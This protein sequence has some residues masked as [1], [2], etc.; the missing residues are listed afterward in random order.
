MRDNTK[1]YHVLKAIAEHDGPATCREI[2]DEMSEEYRPQA[3]D[4]D[5]E[6]WESITGP[7]ARLFGSHHVDRRKRDVRYKPMEYWLAAKGRK[8]LQEKG[9]LPDQEDT[10][11]PVPEPTNSDPDE[12]AEEPAPENAEEVT[13]EDCGRTLDVPDGTLPGKVLGGH[14]THCDGEDVW[15]DEDATDTTPA[16]DPDAI[17]VDLGLDDPDVD[18]GEALSSALA[19]IVSTLRSLEAT[20][21]TLRGSAVTEGEVEDRLQNTVHQSVMDRVDTLQE[22]V[23]ALGRRASQQDAMDSEFGPFIRRL[24]ALER[25]GYG[26]YEGDLSTSYG[27]NV[28]EVRVKAKPKAKTDQKGPEMADAD[29]SGAVEHRSD[30]MDPGGDTRRTTVQKGDSQ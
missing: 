28:Q 5:N 22:Q 30:G 9:D 27:G 17:R 13:C 11:E 20:V 2:Y 14:Q 7:A 8:V 10:D 15:T 3:H 23:N 4:G 24:Q 12:T 21:D 18:S 19:G 16:A 1:K 25:R 6:A 26:L 29:E